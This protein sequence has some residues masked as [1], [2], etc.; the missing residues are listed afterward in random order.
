MII[1][2]PYKATISRVIIILVREREIWLKK[3]EVKRWRMFWFNQVLLRKWNRCRLDMQTTPILPLSNRD[4]SQPT[5][6]KGNFVAVLKLVIWIAIQRVKVIAYRFRSV[7]SDVDFP[8][9]IHRTNNNFRRRRI[10]SCYEI[11]T[12]V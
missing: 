1:Y 3:W 10:K 9:R 5:R 6:Q 12:F 7:A 2:C 11:N 4:F 8:T